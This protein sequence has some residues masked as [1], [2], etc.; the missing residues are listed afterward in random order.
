MGM[1][2]SL[3]VRKQSYPFRFTFAKFFEVYQDL[4][5]G[6]NGSKNFRTLEQQNVNFRTLAK[7]IFNYVDQKPTEK[8]VLYG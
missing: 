8:E 2:D 5:M 1:L 4:D 3:K 6:E 7:E